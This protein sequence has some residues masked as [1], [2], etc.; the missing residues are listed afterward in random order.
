MYHLAQIN[1]ARLLHPAGDPRSQDFFDALDPINE[2][3]ERSPGFV[4][5]LQDNSGNA[6]N[7][8]AFRDP[9]VI[10]NISVWKTLKDLQAFAY[11]SE[12]VNF[13]KR[14]SE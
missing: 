14:K 12:H 13:F 11:R 7:I 1:I 10:L 5:R 2:L 8:H 6:T 9:K 3:A 4:W